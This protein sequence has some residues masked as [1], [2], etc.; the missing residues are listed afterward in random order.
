M[1]ELSIFIDESGDFG[2]YLPHAPYYIISMVTHD[3]Q[4]SI[5]EAV[6]KLDSELAKMGLQNHCVHSGPI[7]R[8]QEDYTNM[9]VDD[10]RR[11]LNKM[12][13][14]IKQCPIK[15]ACF[16]I[17][18]IHIN[19]SMEAVGKLSKQIATFIKDNYDYFLSFD[20][21]KVYYDNG[22]TEVTKIL[23]SVFNTL[24]NNVEFRKVVPSEYKLFQ[25][26]DVICTFKLLKLKLENGIFTES[27]RKFFGNV[28]SLKKNYIKSIELKSF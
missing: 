27:E 18:K 1:K 10:R 2:D 17:E 21:V 24:L 8:K 23:S 16:Y 28:K 13:T 9:S 4:H 22:Q 14:F 15:Y 25:A 12:V 19:D 7:I 3:Q 6:N 11:I 20:I 5:V 26:A